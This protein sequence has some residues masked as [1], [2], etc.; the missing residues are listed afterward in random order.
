MHGGMNQDEIE[1]AIDELLT[2]ETP[3]IAHFAFQL[4][5]KRRKHMTNITKSNTMIHTLYYWNKVIEEVREQYPDVEIR[6][7]ESL[8]ANKK[9]VRKEAF[10][11]Y[12]KMQDI[13][14]D[15]LM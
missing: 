2:L 8:A 1:T 10:Y 13:E 6:L 3:P 4:A 7:L 12:S 5:R 14:T 11:I 9:I 15:D